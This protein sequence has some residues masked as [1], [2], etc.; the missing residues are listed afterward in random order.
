MATRAKQAPVPPE[1]DSFVRKVIADPVNPPEPILLE[2]FLGPSG[3]EGE[4]RLFFNLELTDYVDIPL[5]KV[6]HQEKRPASVAPMGGYYVWIDKDA[7]LKHGPVGQERIQ[8]KWLEGRIRQE[9]K[10][11]WQGKGITKSPCAISP[12]GAG[13]FCP[14]QMQWDLPRR[15]A[16]NPGAAAY[17]TDAV[18]AQIMPTPSTIDCCEPRRTIACDWELPSVATVGICCWRITPNSGYCCRP[19]LNLADPACRPRITLGQVTCFQQLTPG[20]QILT[21]GCPIQVT[22]QQWQ[23]GIFNPYPY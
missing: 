8:A 7:Q 20:L 11:F 12:T 10:A 5:D 4:V 1:F 9:Y 23:M 17:L 18:G 19:T 3:N 16:V 6:L 14:P 22:P 21:Q 15:Y 2:G 13:I